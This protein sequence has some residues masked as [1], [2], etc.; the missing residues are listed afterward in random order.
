M[1]AEEADNGGGTR[2]N[3][4]DES[5]DDRFMD[6]LLLELYQHQPLEPI[7][8]RVQHQ[9]RRVEPA[10]LRAQSRRRPW[11]S[12]ITVLA[13]LLV[14]CLFAMW[15]TAGQAT[16]LLQR[17]VAQAEV[18]EN[19][20]YEVSV[21]GRVTLKARLWVQGGDR[22][23]LRLP[24][25]IPQ[26]DAYTWVGCNGQQGWFVPATGP[27]LILNKPEKLQALVEQRF[28]SLPILHVSTLTRRLKE[29]YEVPVI[30]NRQGSCVKMRLMAK[31]N[32]PMLWP[33][34]VE[35]T[36]QD[37][38][39]ETLTLRWAPAASNER[40][41]MTFQL[42]QPGS[43]AANWYDHAAHHTDA[44]RVFPLEDQP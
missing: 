11:Y 16:E 12:A 9:L 31:S 33:R 40:K 4:P 44:R 25:L 19:R 2:M 37:A 36:A 42:Q 38:V 17:V 15:P 43:V 34:V 26:Q 35:L 8:R 41:T 23:V 14:I 3:K 1:Y 29:G 32:A 39:I 6:A 10:R 13:S 21:E 30:E 22:F 5:L 7:L 28:G 27:V 20:E 24:A 18:M